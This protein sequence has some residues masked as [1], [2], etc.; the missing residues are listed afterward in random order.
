MLGRRLTVFVSMLCL[1]S[2]S[3]SNRQIAGAANS[4]PTCSQSELHVDYDGTL[5]GTGNFNMFFLVKNVSARSCSLRGFPRASFRGAD[6]V[7]LRVSQ[8]ND[9]DRDGND[10]G[11][12]SPGVKIPRVVLAA[13]HGVAS[14]SVY[15]RDQPHVNSLKGCQEWRRMLIELPGARGF[16]TVYALT[17]HE[18]S[19]LWCGGIIMHPVVPGPSGTD[20]PNTQIPQSVASSP[21]KLIEAA[22]VVCQP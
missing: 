21:Q 8:G 2:L 11:G 6:D 22:S 10:L 17:S 1:I 19:F 18:M 15:G 5:A 20:P 12:L 9:P 16:A 3:I 14:F 4:V 13:G 7:R